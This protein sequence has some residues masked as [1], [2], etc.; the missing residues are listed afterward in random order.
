LAFVY[1]QWN[2]PVLGFL[3]FKLVRN[4]I[5]LDPSS[6]WSKIDSSSTEAIL[7]LSDT[8]NG[9]LKVGARGDSDVVRL[10]TFENALKCFQNGDSVAAMYITLFACCASTLC[11]VNLFL[12]EPRSDFKEIQGKEER[13]RKMK[14]NCDD[15]MDSFC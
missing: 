1:V 12:S 9:Q 11:Q 10:F 15:C 5:Y 4:P 3:H 13:K 8:L 2:V 7:H 6:L 14:K